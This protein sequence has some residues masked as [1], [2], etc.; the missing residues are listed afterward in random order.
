M[1]RVIGR[2]H[3]LFPASIGQCSMCACA[4]VKAATPHRCLNRDKGLRLHPA[5]YE[6]GNRLNRRGAEQTVKAESI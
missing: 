6:E 5:R 3:H 1:S 4:R 2:D